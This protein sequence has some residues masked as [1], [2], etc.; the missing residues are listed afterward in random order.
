[1]CLWDTVKMCGFK[2]II[3]LVPLL[4]DLPSLSQKKKSSKTP[5]GAIR[6]EKRN[7]REREKSSTIY[8]K[9]AQDLAS[10]H[11]KLLGAQE[12]PFGS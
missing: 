1:M 10:E 6:K 4:S 12:F 7:R 8:P 2:R 3:S 11:R 9:P 5:M